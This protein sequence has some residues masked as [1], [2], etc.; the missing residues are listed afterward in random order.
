MSQSFRSKMISALA[1]GFVMTALPVFGQGV[2]VE[3]P[4][5]TTATISVQ[6]KS[7]APLDPA[8]LKLQ[9][10]GQDTP[11]LSVKP[12]PPP[13][14]QIAI[15]IDDGLR[16]GFG[17]QLDDFATFI[18]S[19]PPGAKVLVGYMQNGTVRGMNTFTANHQAAA[20]Q[21]RIPMSVAGVNGSPYFTLSEFAKHWPSNQPGARFV[22]LVTNGVDPYNGRPSVMNQNS[23]YVQTAQEDAQRAGVAVYSIYYPQSGMR[24]GRGSFSG[25][26]YLAQVG[27]ASGGTSF[28]MGTITPPSL[29]PYL[30]EFS[31]AIA[32][33]YLVRFNVSSARVKRD[34]LIRIKLKTTQPGVKIQTPNNVHPGVDLMW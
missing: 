8:L 1:A 5:P 34:T 17:N 24:G 18:N 20:A 22:L 21:L 13:G 28:N 30:N 4:L 31:K 33:S 15:L 10:N 7:G 32:G 16:S 3:G 27:E 6:S 12:I 14:A 19:L 23:P 25:Q 2:P 26:S 9:V 29:S 11:I